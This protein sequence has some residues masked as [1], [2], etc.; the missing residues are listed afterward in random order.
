M[1]LN[2]ETTKFERLRIVLGIISII[3][4]TITVTVVG[5]LFAYGNTFVWLLGLGLIAAGVL[6]ARSTQVVRVL[7][8]LLH[9]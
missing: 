1:K 9:F 4:G 7:Y 3:S 6:I 2:T 8:E 5:A